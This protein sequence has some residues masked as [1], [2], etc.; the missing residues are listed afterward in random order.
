[1]DTYVYGIV[2]RG[3]AGRLSAA[4]VD[5]QPIRTVESGGLA[6]LVSDAPSVPVKANR[7]N[8]MAHSAVLQELVADNCVL[9]MRFG[10]VMPSSEAVAAE[11][12]DEHA[13]QLGAQLD[14]FAPYVELEVRAL[15]PEDALLTAVVAERP[16]IA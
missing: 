2:R 7:R 4:G 12:L 13:D 16:A 11:L 8:L 10:V 6:A 5:E 14:A 1:M 9:P 3:A 15:A